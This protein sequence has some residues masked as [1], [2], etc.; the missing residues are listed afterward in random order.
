MGIRTSIEWT[1]SSINAQMGCDGCELYNPKNHERGKPDRCYAFYITRRY[2]GKPG[3]PD[4]FDQPALFPERFEKIGRWSDLTGRQRKLKPWLNGLPRH[5][6]HGDM[7]DYFTESL[8]LDWMA[9]YVP[10]MAEM[11]HVHMMLTKRPRRM[12][13][14]FNELGHVPDNFMLGTSVTSKATIGRAAELIGS[15]RHLTNRFFLSVEPL[16]EDVC[17]DERMSLGKLFELDLD[18]SNLLV[19]VGGESGYEARPF[20][21]EWA[22]RIME[23]CQKKHIAFFM[24]QTGSNV[25]YNGLKYPVSSKGHR[26][27]DFPEHL[28]V[29]MMSYDRGYFML[30]RSVRMMSEVS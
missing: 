26:L 10:T 5:I 29:R 23:L 15:L 12:G 24:K 27:T 7:G 16:V 8:D 1:D 17:T 22:E 9:P 13:R 3:W 14:F 2:G 28:R 30:E 25:R 4:S 21:L 11:P 6:F 19:I 20:H 18:L